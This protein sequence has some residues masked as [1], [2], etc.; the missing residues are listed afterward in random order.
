MT[1]ESFPMIGI[2]LALVSAAVLSA[3]NL[4]QSR[5]VKSSRNRSGSVSVA[6]PTM[7]LVRNRVWLLGAVMLGCAILL[8]MAALVFAP[9]MVVQ[10]LGVTS[11]IFATLIAAFVLKKRPTKQVLLA[12]AVCVIGVAIFV[13]VAALVS[14]Q[15]A[16]DD[17]QL[18]A[19]LVVLGGVLAVAVIFL[20]VDR[21]VGAPPIMW[22][23]LGGVFS[24]F[25]ATLGKTVILRIQTAL[26]TRDFDFDGTNVLTIGC[27][28]G[29]GVAGGLSIYFVQRAHV[30]NRPD[31]VL[32]G[33]TV[34]DPAVAVIMGIAV[35]GEA[36]AA[37][38]WAFVAFAVG[39]VT[40]AAGVLMLSR[41]ER[42]PVDA[43]ES[44][45]QLVND[46]NTS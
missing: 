17:A 23:L 41:A 7:S 28:V 29:I 34:V 11:L 16:V 2:A 1:A 24:A 44:S 39:G 8:Q 33:L 22:V 38:P 18:I 19:V 14:T 4:L 9:L 13:T 36:S 26:R 12:I 43:Y 35:L 31:V 32:A 25:V 15:H 37:P 42:E 6:V 20:I 45:P 3:G 5:G 40:A 27:I 21:R 30:A 46:E 10:P